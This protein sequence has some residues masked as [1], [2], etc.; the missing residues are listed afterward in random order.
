MRDKFRRQALEVLRDVTA[1]GDDEDREEAR[2]ALGLGLPGALGASTFCR[3]I[4]SCAIR[5]VTV[6]VDSGVLLRND[7][8][9]PA[10]QQS[11]NYLDGPRA[12]RS[13]RGRRRAAEPAA[14]AGA[15]R[16]GG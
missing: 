11:R 1:A 10:G 15:A 8:V 2:I 7:C 14:Q 4:P 5:D 13:R 6:L 3:T 12:R 9:L 16:P